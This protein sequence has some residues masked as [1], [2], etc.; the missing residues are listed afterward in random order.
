[1]QYF[2]VL[3]PIC[4]N[5]SIK[6]DFI[7]V[8][9]SDTPTTKSKEVQEVATILDVE[10]QDGFVESLE[11]PRN[12]FVLKGNQSKLSRYIILE[13]RELLFPTGNRVVQQFL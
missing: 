4:R 9:R 13:F 6:I 3:F 5:G 10:I 2:N 12:A 11:V 1:M 7:V 8:Y